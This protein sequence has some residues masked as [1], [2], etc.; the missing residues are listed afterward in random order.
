M[1]LLIKVKGTAREQHSKHGEEGLESPD[2]QGGEIES[3]QKE[4]INRDELAPDKSC[5]SEDSKP[6]DVPERLDSLW[7]QYCDDESG[8]YFYQNVLDGSV[9]WEAPSD[10]S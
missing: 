4:E 2:Y 3:V 8:H 9:T 6:S 5:G 7:I 10:V 1:L